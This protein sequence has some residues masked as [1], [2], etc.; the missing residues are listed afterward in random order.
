MNIFTRIVNNLK[1]AH[2]RKIRDRAMSESVKHAYDKD[3]TEFKRQCKICLEASK[4]CIEIPL[5]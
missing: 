2:Y 4:K 3:D 5:H 1:Y